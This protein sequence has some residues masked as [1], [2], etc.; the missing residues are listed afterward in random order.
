MWCDVFLKFMQANNLK[1]ATASESVR[2]E[3][4][5]S[6]PVPHKREIP[7]SF[8]FFPISHFSIS[9]AILCSKR[10][11]RNGLLSRKCM[12][13]KRWRLY[14]TSFTKDMHLQT[15]GGER[16]CRH[17]APIMSRYS[18]GNPMRKGKG[19]IHCHWFAVLSPAWPY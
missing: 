18:T 2:Y 7:Y 1:T 12:T 11:H 3:Y 5:S 8:K 13:L 4:P 16:N 19:Y 9:G 14:N 15:A 10:S 17:S 6:V